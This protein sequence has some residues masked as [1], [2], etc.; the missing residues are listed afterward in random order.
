MMS[1]LNGLFS[2]THNDDLASMNLQVD[3]SHQKK[4]TTTLSAHRQTLDKD[5]APSS[6]S[7][8]GVVPCPHSH[9]SSHN[10]AAAA[11]APEPNWRPTGGPQREDRDGAREHLVGNTDY[12]EETQ[13]LD[14][15]GENK[16]A[17][18]ALGGEQAETCL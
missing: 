13:C 9:P 12:D 16:D 6:S 10:I 18:L 2:P 4:P 1:T 17:L 7:P 11:E 8:A 3:A 15:V 5:L 14:V